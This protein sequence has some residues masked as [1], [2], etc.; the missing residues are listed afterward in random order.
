MR[1]IGSEYS[2]ALHSG[3]TPCIDIR[4]SASGGILMKSG[5]SA[6]D[7][8]AAMI[9]N[10]GKEKSVAM[11]SWC[12]GSMLQPFVERGWRISFYEIAFE[13]EKTV[14][15]GEIPEDVSLLYTSSFFGSDPLIE[16]N[17]PSSI[18]RIHDFTHSFLDQTVPDAEFLVASIRK[19]GA[20]ATGGIFI[21]KEELP[22]LPELKRA[23]GSLKFRAM[24]MKAD[25]LEKG[26][27]DKNAFLELFSSANHSFEEEY[28][29]LGI[30]SMS[31]S[32]YQKWNI[33]E[34]SE[35]R[36]RNAGLLREGLADIDEIR[37]ILPDSECH[38]PLFVPAMVSGGK[39]DALRQHLTAQEIYLP[40]HW[41]RPALVPAG[42]SRQLFEEEL[43]LVCDQRY[44]EEDMLRIIQT[45]KTFFRK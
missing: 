42:L 18:L 15:K 22:Y 8:A 27:D 43:S 19:W 39:R 21:S 34:I 6:I 24:Q 30:D 44:G 33:A 26:N 25:Y 28:S 2:L 13:D 7:L 20:I 4:D 41:P 37:C 1:E 35:I 12:C 45:I 9:E 11:P 23:D 38:V 14:L 29:M 3:C 32:L 36:R 17:P 5:R 31:N 16:I 10:S 40:V